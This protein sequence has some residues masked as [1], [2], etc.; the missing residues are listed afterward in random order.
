LIVVV[1]ASEEL[2]GAERASGCGPWTVHEIFREDIGGRNGETF[3][4]GE[5]VESSR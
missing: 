1:R 3:F 2:Y 5:G 4:G